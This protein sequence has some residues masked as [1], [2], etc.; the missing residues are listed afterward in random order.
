MSIALPI[1][2]ARVSKDGCSMNVVSSLFEYVY[3]TSPCSP[4]ENRL[5]SFTCNAS[6]HDLP[7]PD[8]PL[9][10]DESRRHYALFD[11]GL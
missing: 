7:S 5:S 6:Y 2:G 3:E 10:I 1:E 8:R 4:F 9:A 11:S